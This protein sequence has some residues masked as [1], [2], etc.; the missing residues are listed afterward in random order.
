MQD[1]SCLGF[2][3]GADVGYKLDSSETEL[4]SNTVYIL[5]Y[6]VCRNSLNND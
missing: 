5:L 4:H 1:A 6:F 2:H 3:L